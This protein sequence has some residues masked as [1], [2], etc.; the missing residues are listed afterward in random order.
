[1]YKQIS[2]ASL[3]YGSS[4]KGLGM[5]VSTTGALIVRL[6]EKEK[7]SGVGGRMVVV[8]GENKSQ[9]L[10]KQQVVGGDGGGGEDNKGRP[11]LKHRN[12]SS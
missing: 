8:A 3:T 7:E 1:M 11:I 9:S 5:Q 2:I 10:I 6:A 4:L 12:S